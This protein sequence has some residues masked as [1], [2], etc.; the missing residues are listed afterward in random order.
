MHALAVLLDGQPLDHVVVPTRTRR[1]RRIHRGVAVVVSLVYAGLGIA[2]VCAA[3]VAAA[4]RNAVPLVVAGKQVLLGDGGQIG[5]GGLVGGLAVLGGRTRLGQGERVPDAQT[6]LQL[7]R[8]QLCA[9][10][11]R[12][13][14]HGAAAFGR[15]Q[16]GRMQLSGAFFAR[17]HRQLVAEH[18]VAAVEERCGGRGSQRVI[19]AEAEQRADVWPPE[20]SRDGERLRQRVTAVGLVGVLCFAAA[21]AGGAAR[22][23]LTAAGRTARS[24]ARSTV[25]LHEWRCGGRGR[26]RGGSGGGAGGGGGAEG[27]GGGDG[28]G[29]RSGTTTRGGGGG[30]GSG[31]GGGAGVITREDGAAGG[32]VEERRAGSKALRRAV[33][34]R[35]GAA[36]R[37]AATAER[38]GQGALRRE[39]AGRAAVVEEEGDGGCV[40]GGASEVQ[41]SA[42]VAGARIRLGAGGDEEAGGEGT[43]LSGGQVQRGEA[44]AVGERETGALAT[45]Q[46]QEVTVE[47]DERRLR[48]GAQQEQVE[49][50]EASHPGELVGGSSGGGGV[51][52][53]ALLALRVLLGGGGGHCGRERTA[54]AAAADGVR[55]GAEAEQEHSDA[56]VAVV[57]GQLEGGG[58]GAVAHVDG[59]LRVGAEEPHVGQ[60]ARMSSHRAHVQQRASALLLAQRHQRLATAQQLGHQS[61]VAAP[62]RRHQVRRQTAEVHS[63]RTRVPVVVAG[64]RRDGAGGGT[65]RGRRHGARAGG[66]GRRRGTAQREHGRTETGQRRHHRGV[67]WMRCFARDTTVAT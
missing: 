6:Q 14:E 32:P 57:T 40:A 43:T 38:A 48:A 47:R 45:E 25:L 4:R 52:A 64:A 16:V 33:V 22:A 11:A 3:Q 12:Q 19:H 13:G 67:C 59:R 63:R 50:A 29:T 56:H 5:G 15:E 7:Q 31:G 54:A 8:V 36:G 46:E 9:A 39:A 61:A 62:R 1:R 34:I 24:T 41:R 65:T 20:A 21:A 17:A 27:G 18:A 28:G 35:G 30:A 37:G 2:R 55:V 66:T 26:S 42:A 44:G 49:R 23:Q 60:E 51:R 10:E 58:A 53:V